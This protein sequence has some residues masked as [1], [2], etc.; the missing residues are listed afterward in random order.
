V[1]GADA[2]RREHPEDGLGHH[3]HVEQ[4]AVALLHSELAQHSRQPGDLVP[5]LLKGVRGHAA[6]HGAVV[7]QGGTLAPARRHVEVDRVVAGVEPPAREPGG[8]L[9]VP[10]VEHRARSAHP[11]D[12]L[13][14]SCPERLGAV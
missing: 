11:L 3:R 14:G 2:R 9:R 4:Y 7:H 5:Q 1:D 13:G 8:A 10:V 12:V 6:R